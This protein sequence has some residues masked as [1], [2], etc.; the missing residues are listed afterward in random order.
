MSPNHTRFFWL[1]GMKE[2]VSMIEGLI[3]FFLLIGGR[4]AEDPRG[5]TL[6]RGTEITLCVLFLFH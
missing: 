5:N 2:V 4:I 6:G 1:L 3:V